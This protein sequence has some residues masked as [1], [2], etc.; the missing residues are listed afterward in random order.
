MIPAKSV[1]VPLDA[2]RGGTST[3]QAE[4][5]M[6]AASQEA[7]LGGYGVSMDDGRPPR[8]TWRS[9]TNFMAST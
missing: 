9:L 5:R 7:A 3:D 4:K 6:S 2:R 1:L 8:K